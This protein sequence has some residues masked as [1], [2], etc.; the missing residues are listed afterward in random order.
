MIVTTGAMLLVVG[1]WATL[2]VNVLESLRTPSLTTAVTRYDPGVVGVP[3]IS[4]VVDVTASPTQ[5][6]LPKP[7]AAGR[8]AAKG[9]RDGALVVSAALTIP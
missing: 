7:V 3:L 6:P 4:P 1:A 2:H 8:V 9:Y 5:I